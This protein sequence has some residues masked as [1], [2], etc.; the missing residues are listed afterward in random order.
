ML[1]RRTFAALWTLVAERLFA[2]NK[3]APSATVF[4]KTAV[5]N[6]VRMKIAELVAVKE[7]L[8]TPAT[9]FV[10]DLGC[11]SLD[12]VELV[13]EGDELFGI[14]IKDE[15]VKDLVTVQKATDYIVRALKLQRR[16]QG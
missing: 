15:D 16:I 13:M 9:R 14:S 7:S 5:S 10:E 1:N 3:T 12:I 6:L 8:V 11:D 4:Q 2:Q